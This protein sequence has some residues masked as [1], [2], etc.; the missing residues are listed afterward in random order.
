MGLS[1]PGFEP[2][3]FLLE[4][5]GGGGGGGRGVSCF[6]P[7]SLRTS[8]CSSKRAC[9]RDMDGDFVF[10]RGFA[11][12]NGAAIFDGRQGRTNDCYFFLGFVFFRGGGVGAPCDDAEAIKMTNHLHPVRWISMSTDL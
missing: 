5:I 7:M 9:S 4:P 2:L 8:C 10:V 11:A 6:A 3:P 1:R 12:S